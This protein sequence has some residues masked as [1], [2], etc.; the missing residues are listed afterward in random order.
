MSLA[1]FV[2]ASCAFAPAGRPL[3]RPRCAVAMFDVT[4]PIVAGGASLVALAALASRSASEP[5]EGSD[6]Q[7]RI[8]EASMTRAMTYREIPESRAELD[9]SPEAVAQREERRRAV[10]ARAERMLAA[11]RESVKE[12]LDEALAFDDY[13]GAEEMQQM[14]DKLAPLPEGIGP[15]ADSPDYRRWIDPNIR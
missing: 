1:V 8:R 9:M 13:E 11:A 6:I 15:T 7:A 5:S 14:L 4:G 3:V 12:G 10:Y 2:A